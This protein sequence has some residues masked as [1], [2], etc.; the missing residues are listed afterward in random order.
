M[1]L[2][3]GLGDPKIRQDV[4][5]ITGNVHT[6]FEKDLPKGVNFRGNVKVL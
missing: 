5:L 1:T 2:T 6:K 3:F 4:E